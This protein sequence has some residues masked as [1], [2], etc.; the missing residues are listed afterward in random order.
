MTLKK[1]Q[2]AFIVLGSIAAS[3]ILSFAIQKGME[4]YYG[5]EYLDLCKMYRDIARGR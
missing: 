4:A 2:I 3:G 5:P 1:S